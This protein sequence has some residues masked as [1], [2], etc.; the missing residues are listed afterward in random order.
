MPNDSHYVTG[1][2]R[3][4]PVSRIPGGSAVYLVAALVVGVLA[5][6]ILL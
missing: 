1:Y 6:A 2:D 3:E 5:L 4:S